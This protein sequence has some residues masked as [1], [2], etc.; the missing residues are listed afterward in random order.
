MA[1]PTIPQLL[2]RRVQLCNAI[3]EIKTMRRGTLNEVYKKQKLKSGKI[4]QRGPFY[5]ITTKTEKNKTATTAVPKQDVEHV[6]QEVERYRNFR[7]LSDEYIEICEKLSLLAS[8]GK[9]KH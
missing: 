4:A 5:N 6:R 8:G 3:A 7:K 1:T 2:E 9:P